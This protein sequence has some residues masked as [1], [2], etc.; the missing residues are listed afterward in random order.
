MALDNVDGFTNAEALLW[1]GFR[2]PF[3]T[4]EAHTCSLPEIDIAISEDED[5]NRFT[6]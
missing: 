1:A 6:R 3:A 2:R 4:N 5:E